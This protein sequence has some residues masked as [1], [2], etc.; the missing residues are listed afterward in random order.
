MP[1]ARGKKKKGTQWVH[2]SIS[3]FVRFVGKNASEI[4]K[5]RVC[6]T[7]SLHAKDTHMIL[8]TCERT[9]TSSIYL[10]IP[11]YMKGSCT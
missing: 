3:I 8:T 11:Q 6:D 7:Y 2:V 5:F 10:N 9:G 1:R 4:M